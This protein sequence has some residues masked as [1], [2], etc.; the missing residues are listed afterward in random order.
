[1]SRRSTV[2]SRI[3]YYEDKDILYLQILPERP[4]KVEETRY[5]FMVRYDWDDPEVIVGFECL[6]FSLLVPH[7][8]ERGVLPDVK[9]RFDI[10]GASLKGATL[11]GVLIWAYERYVLKPLMVPREAFLV[12]QEAA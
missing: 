11:K 7:L 10:E 12:A 8:A 9:M 4:A 6:D 5:G 1:M 2:P 3:A